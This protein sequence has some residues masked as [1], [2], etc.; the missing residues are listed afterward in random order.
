MTTRSGAPFDTG[1]AVSALRARLTTPL[2]PA[3]PAADEDDPATGEWA[4]TRGDG[5]L[6]FPLWEGEPLTG[7]YGP[8]W[9]EAETAAEAHLRA[10]TA[11]LDR[12][13]GPHRTV[14]LPVPPLRA[15][16]EGFPEPFRTLAAKDCY[17]DLTVWG[18]L[19]GAPER[20]AAVS[21]NQSDGDAPLL[22]TALISA[23]PL[24]EPAGPDR[25]R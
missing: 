23:R 13:W 1:R 18:P 3:G 22:L 20:W 17:G 2:P 14:P 12:H 10:L 11:E 9:N 21:L 4:L 24:T 25:R 16:P 6:L 8:A 5:F 15:R 7:V 19:P